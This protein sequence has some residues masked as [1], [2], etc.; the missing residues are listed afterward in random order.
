MLIAL[1][2]PGHRMAR[3]AGAVRVQRLVRRWDFTERRARGGGIKDYPDEWVCATCAWAK[4]SKVTLE[5][6]KP[7]QRRVWC[8]AAEEWMWHRADR[9]CYEEPLEIMRER[10]AA[11]DKAQ[12]QGGSVADTL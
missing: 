3:T 7:G 1:V 4:G 6:V 2:F 11:N 10:E 12:F 5:V 8:V 9:P